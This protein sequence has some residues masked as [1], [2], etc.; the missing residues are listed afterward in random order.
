MEDEHFDRWARTIANGWVSRRRLMRRVGGAT[1]VA[2]LSGLV[3]DDTQG[4]GKKKK[5]KKSKKKGK[6]TGQCPANGRI[7]DFPWQHC[8]TQGFTCG[9]GARLDG[10]PFCGD[11]PVCIPGGCTSDADCVSTW[12]L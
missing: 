3:L 10:S 1:L 4:K 7:C 11:C 9:C 6:G 2:G 12:G 8:D 5:K